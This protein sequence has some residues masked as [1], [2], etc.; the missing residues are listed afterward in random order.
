[1]YRVMLAVVLLFG[2]GLVTVAAADPPPNQSTSGDPAAEGADLDL[3]DVPVERALR[4]L[5]EIF[6]VS[7]ATGQLPDVRVSMRLRD[8]G[9][10]DAFAA[11]ATVA[12]LTVERHGRVVLVAPKAEAGE[13][14]RRVVPG[15]SSLGPSY[16]G[17]VG[18]DVEVRAV[19]YGLLLEGPETSVQAAA[20]ALDQARRGAVV[21]RVFPLGVAPGEET[22]Q[23]VQPL[24]EV[25]LEHAAYDA[26]GHLLT[27]T[28]LPRKLDRVAS[29]LAELGRSPRQ[30]EI[31][32][33]VVEVSQNAL[34][35]MGAQGF[36][37]LDVRGGLLPTTFPLRGL[38]DGSRYFPS[39]NELA[40]L[41][42]LAGVGTGG[43]NGDPEGSLGD[44]GFR[45]GR[46]DGRGI[47]LL[48]EF[49]EESGAARVM[50]TPRVT[51][52]DNRLAQIS[53]VTTLRIPTFT[54]NDA[55]AT[56][57]VS[58]IEEVDVGT[59][60]AVRPRRG[61]GREIWLTVTPE[62]SELEPV[63]S[64]FAQNGLTQG[65][66]VVTRRRTE[67][68]VIL[69]SGETLV[70]GGLVR[71]REVETL[72]K[73]PG[74]GD[75]PVIGRAFRHKGKDSE[76][77]ELLVFVTPRELPP[78]E[79]RRTRVRVDDAWI[80]AELAARVDAARAALAEEAPARRVVGVRTLERLDADLR[81]E[82]LDLAAD[83]LALRTDPAL[84]ARA[85]AAL[86]LLR[87]RPAVAVAE[88]PGFVGSRD[89]A[90]AVL[91][92]PFAPHLRAAVAE[93]VGRS[94]GGPEAIARRLHA[95]IGAG[96]SAKAGRLL[97]AL[98]VA[99][100]RRAAAEAAVIDAAAAG[101]PAPTFLLDALVGAEEE[102][103]LV[104]R[105]ANDPS[106]EVRAYAAAA[107]A[108]AGAAPSATEPAL[109][110]SG[111]PA[112]PE[113]LGDAMSVRRVDEALELLAREAP[114][115]RHGVGFALARI[116]AGT[117]ETSVDPSHRSARIAVA[118]TE[119]L[120]LAQRLVRLAAIVFESRVR[121]YEASGQRNLAR[122]VREEI[123]TLERLTGAPCPSERIRTIVEEVLDAAVRREGPPG[124]VQPSVSTSEG[125]FP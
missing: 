75:I 6:D 56:T 120:H 47:G 48:I 118:G 15:F 26:T 65:L 55:F 80:P 18:D 103:A 119:P 87:T 30:F 121:G 1:M 12:G 89:V 97:E 57:T 51:T 9:A 61:E 123:R 77:S 42:D 25:G 81:A 104:R 8:V 29:L 71:E 54:Q 108:L 67:T 107:Q 116:V 79:V 113:I 86:F 109:A 59:V 102:N 44:S 13:L 96:S 70:I 74:L 72:G 115:L 22:L 68:E 7:I 124:D 37:R 20:D 21:D 94:D 36:F 2:I 31:E 78:P 99:S 49:L 40:T 28:A 93:L 32:V 46:I 90:V 4:F 17:L 10:E 11:V 60:L 76:S 114:D 62:V 100:P 98:T 91:E 43:G 122:A 50:A 84:E 125:A 95:T 53:M 73:T 16:E 34:R 83:I 45:F 117:A 39:P 38:D 19:G 24:L 35:R 5:A 112:E 110:W 52:L 27:V 88:L 101:A 111:R 105:S 63:V 66:P 64:S 23:A 58:G 14:R 92:F 69:D 41:R 85:A 82:D 3:D 33:Q 106:S